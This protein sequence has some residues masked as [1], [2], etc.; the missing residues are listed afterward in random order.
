MIL[1]YISIVP[2]RALA[3][4]RLVGAKN[5]LKKP[6]DMEELRSAVDNILKKEERA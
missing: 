5:I 4:A 6:F 3:F 2:V 1:K